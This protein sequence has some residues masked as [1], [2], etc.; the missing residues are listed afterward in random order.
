[1]T[2][3]VDGGV[4]V[5]WRVCGRK[6]RVALCDRCAERGIGTEA[7]G[8]LEGRPVT[9]EARL[10]P[11]A[12]GSAAVRALASPTRIETERLAAI[13]D[14]YR[15]HYDEAPDASLTTRW[16]G[17][18]LSSGRLEAFVAEDNGGFV[19]FALTMPVPASL[20]LGHFWQIRDLFV[21]P[22]HRRLGI[23]GALLHVI[24]AAAIDAGASRLVLQTEADN[25]PALGLYTAS[26]Y[27]IVE[28]YHS[29]T[30]PLTPNSPVS[31]RGSSSVDQ[32]V[33]AAGL[34]DHVR[35][36]P[37]GRRAR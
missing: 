35:G 21:L 22:N 33:T 18:H 14:R 12:G 10:P 32:P 26:G 13:F 16:L 17:T 6:V 36:R 20:R 8:G 29:L 28:G 9:D 31:E 7:R 4:D 24:R 11:A 2:R 5:D 25:A 27:T 3:L 37:P 15:A 34:E 1:M 23:G 19:G 30:L